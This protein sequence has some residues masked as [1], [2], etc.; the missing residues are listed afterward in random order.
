MKRK[1]KELSE[2]EIFNR[3]ASY[4]AAAERCCLDVRNTLQRLEVP[5]DVADRVIAALVREKYIDEARYCRAFIHDKYRFAKWGRVK[6]VQMLK[7][8]KIPGDIYAPLLDEVIDPEEYL[9]IL[10]AL[11]AAHRRSIRAGSE[12]ELRNKLVRF[13]VGRGYEFDE[14][15]A[16]LE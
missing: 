16:A 2:V 15:Q 1:P 6:I 9:S 10:R 7:M 14:I 12:F 4:C 11:L 5:D 8:K 3:V 13:A